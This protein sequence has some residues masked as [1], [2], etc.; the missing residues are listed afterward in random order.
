M[1]PLW[2]PQQSVFVL[3]V[4]G[5]LD[6]LKARLPG[7]VI[8][9]HSDREGV[10][11]LVERGT[12]SLQVLLPAESTNRDGFATDVPED[13]SALTLQ[14]RLLERLVALGT[15]AA[16][17]PRRQRRG[18]IR[19][20]LVLRSLDGWR[21]GES[22]RAI[23]SILWGAVRVQREWP[24]GRLRDTVRRAIGRGRYLMGGGYLALLRRNP[25]TLASK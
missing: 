10:H 22:Q 25:R 5:S 20:I 7:C 24:S 9:T 12:V 19:D 8:V 1:Q 18:A 3:R 17:P 15:E 14:S 23:A 13:A 21:A 6:E 4:Y 2:L 16:S 11:V